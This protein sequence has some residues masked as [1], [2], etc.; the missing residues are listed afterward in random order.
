MFKGNVFNALFCLPS[1]SL[2]CFI[3]WQLTGGRQ[4]DWY[5]MSRCDSTVLPHPLTP[6]SRCGSFQAQMP[7][8]ASRIEQ[9]S[10]DLRILTS[11]CFFFV[12]LTSFLLQ[13]LSHSLPS[14][15][16]SSMP[17]FLSFSLSVPLVRDQ[18]H[19][20]LHP[21]PSTHISWLPL[22]MPLHPKT[23]SSLLP[24]LPPSLFLL[25]CNQHQPHLLFLL[26][27][28]VPLLALYLSSL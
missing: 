11:F 27:S 26:L 13:A 16:L 5:Q 8:E 23:S 18:P 6:I 28:S 15:S 24:S 3:L 17:S 7:V 4:T 21:S 2:P 1:C 20:P 25:H 22:D 12:F 10:S 19:L 9:N 14:L